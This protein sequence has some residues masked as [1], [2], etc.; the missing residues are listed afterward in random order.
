S[1][2]FDQDG[3]LYV[4][5]ACEGVFIGKP[6]DQYA[7]WK[8]LSELQKAAGGEALIHGL[9]PGP[10]RTLY[11]ATTPGLTK[12]SDQEKTWCIKRGRKLPPPA[13]QPETQP[14]PPSTP[15]PTALAEDYLTTLTQDAAGRI[16]IGTRQHGHQVLNPK[17]DRFED[18]DP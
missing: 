16:W 3:T 14:R 7:S 5:G 6:A 2:A 15:D 8:P 17:T 4:A 18:I 13:S 12:N 11:V 10:G 1:L 9:L